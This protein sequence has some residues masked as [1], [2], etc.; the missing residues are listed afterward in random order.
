MVGS[1]RHMGPEKIDLPVSVLGE[2]RCSARSF[3]EMRVA[4]CRLA[5][6]GSASCW[7]LQVHRK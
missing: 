7:E 6:A 2:A 5:L 1:K 4:L 3:S